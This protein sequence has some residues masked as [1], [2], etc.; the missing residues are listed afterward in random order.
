M[1][2]SGFPDDNNTYVGQEDLQPTSVAGQAPDTTAEKASSKAGEKAAFDG[3]GDDIEEAREEAESEDHEA[4]EECDDDANRDLEKGQ[5]LK[6]QQTGTSTKSVNQVTWDGP[7]DEENP[8]NWKNNRK[9][10]A[11]LVVSSFTFISPVSSTMVAPALPNMAAD[12]GITNQVL[13]QMMLSIFVLA[14]AIGPLFLGPLSEVYGRVPVLQ[15]GNIFFLIFN[16]VC[17]FAQTGAQML[18]FRFLAGIGG[19]APLAIG[20]GVLADCF[21]PETRGVAIAVYSLAPLIG[22]AAGPIAGGFIAENTTWRWVFW[23]VTIA[24]ALILAFGVFFLQETWAPK[25]LERKAKKLRK[26]TGNQTLYASK[27]QPLSTKLRT[28]LSRPFILLSSQPI[29]IVF[30]IYMAY[31]Y[32]LVYLVIS[33]FPGLF[34]SPAYY[35]E[36]T[37]IGGLNYITLAVGYFLGAQIGARLNDWTYRRLKRRNNNVGQ[38]EFR[39]PMLW[40]G[41]ILLPIGFFWYGWSAQARVHWIMPDI[42]AGLL[43]FATIF[44]YYSIQ[45]YIIDC[46]TKYAASAVAAITTLRSLAGFGFPLFAPSLYDSLGYGW[47]NSLLA[48]VAIV[49]G[50]PAP[51]L[52][53]KYGAQLRAKSQYAAGS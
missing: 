41:A 14:Y 49:I 5:A 50:L 42:G 51:W 3:P 31:L 37:Q 27:P 13:S 8:K 48:F 19:S 22:P 36:S 29:V 25:L 44:S 10:A 26:E 28:S 34:T 1:Y 21:T 2:S 35:G 39:I 24:D 53:W 52:F 6:R 30:A 17:G 18:V 33:S 20:G 4:E 16:L 45:N 32:G 23:A 15:L 40:P 12:L 47:G 38:P 11:V 9:W 43:A 7:D 46:Y